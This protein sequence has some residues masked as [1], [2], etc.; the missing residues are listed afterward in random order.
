MTRKLSTLKLEGE[1]CFQGRLSEP[2][3]PM[4]AD[5]PRH[6]KHQQRKGLGVESQRIGRLEPRFWAPPPHTDLLGDTRQVSAFSEPWFTYMSSKLVSWGSV[7]LMKEPLW[8]GGLGSN[9]DFNI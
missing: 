7:E 1:F 3:P 9:P 5:M 6:I 8:A 2:L 4:P